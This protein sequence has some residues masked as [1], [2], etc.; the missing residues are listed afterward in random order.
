MS[1]AINFASKALVND[2]KKKF[3]TRTG[4]LLTEPMQIS[5][6]P[7]QRCNVK[8]LMCNCWH[9]KNDHI[10]K[11]DIIHFIEDLHNWLG[12]NYII[13]ISGGEPLIFKGIF[14]IFKFCSEHKI[15]CKITTN[16]YA[17]NK[18]ICDKII[19]SGLTYVSVSL[20]SHLPEVHDK[21]RGQNN[22]FQR[23]IDGINYLRENSDITIGISSIV[24][25]ENIYHLKEFTDFLIN[26]DVDRVLFQPLRDYYNPIEEWTSFKYWVN[27]FDV[28][29]D[30]INYLI[31]KKKTN[32]KLLNT[33]N[34]FELIKRYFRDPYSII[35]SRNC[36]IGYE[37]LSVDHKGEI[38][39]CNAYASIGN[40]KDR[41]I[42]EMWSAK[43]TQEERKNMVSCTLPCTSNCK[44]QLSL[45]EK[46]TKFF[47]LYKSGLF[48]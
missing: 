46:V 23:A 40:I 42:K 43:K 8:C 48:K 28:L 33:I 47:T 35:N 19:E 16:G 10:T 37:Q 7:T 11:D 34:D 2:I 6:S 17:L 36:Y 26:L 27:D 24:M 18:T 30:A 13:H 41:N 22:T 29:D 38:T 14:D 45:N 32:S 5:I 20:D 21:F 12:N 4:I 44:K 15:I 3:S 25:N 1:K 9:E 31:E 39:M